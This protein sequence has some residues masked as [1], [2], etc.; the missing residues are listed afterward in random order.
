[1]N[2]LVCAAANGLWWLSALPESAA[3]HLACRDTASVQKQVLLRLLRR[4]ASTEWGCRYDFG[5]IR[6]VAEYQAR[7]PL[8]TYDDYREA[9]QQIGAGQDHF[10]THESVLLLEPTSGSTAATKYIPYTASLKA[11]FQRAI[12]PWVVDLFRH[13][14]Q[15]LLGQAYWSVTPV[16]RRNQRTPAGI[17]IG[18]EEDSD[19]LGRWQRY[20]LQ[21]V[22]AVPP[23]VRLIDHMDAFRYVT[24]LFLLRS[25]RLA[26]ISVWNPTF[27]L[28]LVEPL[29]RW[30]PQLVAD[31]THG[32]LSPPMA[33]P[34]DLHR[35]LA[36]LNR[37]DPRRAD[38][39]RRVFQ[40]SADPA[41]RHT[42]LWP[43]LRL[44][45]CWTEAQAAL[46]LPKLARL[47]PQAQF[48]GKGLIATEGFVSLPLVGHP[49]A[50]LALRSHFF[51]FAPV[52]AEL[53]LTTYQSSLSNLQL[54]HQLQLGCHYSVILTTGGGL[55]R[56][57]LHDLVEVAGY[58]GGCPLLRFL[59]KEAYI[60][61]WFGEKLNERHVRQVLETLLTRSAIQPT[62]AML[63]CDEQAGR[64]AYTLFIETPQGEDEMLGVLGQDLEQALQQNYHYRYCRDL[65]QLEAVRVFRIEQEGLQTYFA[66]CK[67]HGQRAGD[68]KLAALHRL[69]GWS[70]VFQGRFIH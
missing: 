28:L 11:E 33:L 53:P 20:F 31:I 68:I 2:N 44:I 1:M 32:T 9:V 37:P 8:T 7:V 52:Q 27:L 5:S 24:L 65:G 47:F 13:H 18:F 21:A 15:L 23:L 19:Y 50:A 51:E 17:P 55:Y 59:G 60:S 62:L 41:S 48:Q 64:Y 35:L 30:W 34:A 14:P 43:Y 67:V 22:L 6:S 70:Q 16:T 12:A 36:A 40:A 61:D 57:Q 26:L 54:A 25:R 56:Y 46:H 39:I 63:A 4:N 45:S 3:F 29:S 69:G 49:G 38:Q 58:V 10:L 42:Q 66:A